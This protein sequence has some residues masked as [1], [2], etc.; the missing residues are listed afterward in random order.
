MFDWRAKLRD[1]EQDND[2]KNMWKKF[3]TAGPKKVS[4]PVLSP[5]DTPL[6]RC[7]LLHLPSP[8]PSLP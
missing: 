1:E 4:P 3:D 8:S 6:P 7:E 5:P 2:P